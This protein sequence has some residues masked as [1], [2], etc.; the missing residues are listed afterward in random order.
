MNTK[1]LIEHLAIYIQVAA[2]ETNLSR[3]L[4]ILKASLLTNCLNVFKSLR[5]DLACELL[6]VVK[7]QVQ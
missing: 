6:I 4:V 1:G 5:K 3:N 7:H 2:A